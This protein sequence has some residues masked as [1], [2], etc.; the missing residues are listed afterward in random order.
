MPFA[1]YPFRDSERETV[2]SI[3]KLRDWARHIDENPH[4]GELSDV[5]K[6][7]L[8]NIVDAIEA[9]AVTYRLLRECNNDHGHC[10]LCGSIMYDAPKYCPN[11]GAKVVEE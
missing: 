11:C 8:N 3:E 4:L 2:E 6:W 10:T 5:G 9:E 7:G 1:G